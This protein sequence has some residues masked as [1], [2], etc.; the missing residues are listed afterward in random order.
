MMSTKI[1][2]KSFA[3]IGAFAVALVIPTTAS[4]AVG[5]SVSKATNLV[6][7]EQITIRLAGVPADQGVYI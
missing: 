3:L 4:A 5:V 2:N 7:G 1:R 6:D